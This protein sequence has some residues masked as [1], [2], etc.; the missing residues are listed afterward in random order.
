MSDHETSL[1]EELLSVASDRELDRFL[2][3]HTMELRS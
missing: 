1:T 2:D 3:D